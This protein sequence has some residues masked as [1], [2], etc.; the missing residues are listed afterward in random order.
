[1][2]FVFERFYITE[3]S[4]YVLGKLYKDAQYISN[5]SINLKTFEFC[6][7]EGVVDTTTRSR[8]KIA[9]ENAKPDILNRK[10]ELIFTTIDHFDHILENISSVISQDVTYK[11]IMKLKLL[12]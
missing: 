7:Y 1:M 12:E 2:N 11:D 5:L 10:D 9:I 4:I 6:G 3:D 8:I